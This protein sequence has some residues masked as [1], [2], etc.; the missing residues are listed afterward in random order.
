MR[1]T[2]MNHLQ[3]YIPGSPRKPPL[4]HRLAK[5]EAAYNLGIAARESRNF[6]EAI[7]C[8]R[9]VLELLEG[10]MMTPFPMAL[11]RYSLVAAAHNYLGLIELDQNKGAEASLAFDQAIA[12]RRKLAMFFPSERENKV[13]LGGALCN[14]GFATA[15]IDPAQAKQYYLK[16]LRIL[17]QPKRTCDCSY[18]DEDRQSWWCSHLEAMAQMTGLA[19]VYLAP[20]F[21]DS[22]MTG[23]ASLKPEIHANRLDP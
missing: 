1:F 19:W 6:I 15:E 20:R 5:A 16:S 2:P 14:R 10:G 18:W 12:L 23:L 11:R 17:R 13:Y 7:K 22:A 3:Q 21:I 8:F 4:F 9:V